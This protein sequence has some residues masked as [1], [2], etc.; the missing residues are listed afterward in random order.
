MGGKGASKGISQERGESEK[1]NVS[2][3]KEEKNSKRKYYMIRSLR[4]DKY[5]WSK[6]LNKKKTINVDLNT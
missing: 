4:K 5:F 2:V 3:A 1:S 6:L